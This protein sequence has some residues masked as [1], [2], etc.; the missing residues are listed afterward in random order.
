MQSFLECSL[1]E[2]RRLKQLAE[3]AMDQVPEDRLANVPGSGSNSIAVIVQH[4]AGNLR[5]RWTD[6][7][8]SDGEKPWRDRDREF[9][10]PGHVSASS[11][12]AE[13]ESGWAPLFLAFERLTSEDLLR[14]VEIRGESYTVLQA[15]CRSTSHCAYHVGQLVYVARLLVESQWQNL[16]IPRG[17]SAR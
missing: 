3:R 6:F 8:S 16:S 1:H 10:E 11:L 17:A 14:T 2:F 5:S 13:W 12:R 4:L 7:L 15:I 9:T